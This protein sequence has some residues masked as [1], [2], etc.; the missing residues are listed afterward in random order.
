MQ[1]ETRM[2][3]AVCRKMMA[4]ERVNRR[5]GAV[6]KVNWWVRVVL[7][8]GSKVLGVLLDCSHKRPKPGRNRPVPGSLHDCG[9][10]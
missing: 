9:S 1:V 10:C 4:V 7:Q 8:R 5:L 6:K 2:L 3:K